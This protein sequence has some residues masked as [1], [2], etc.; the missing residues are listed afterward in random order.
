[1]DKVSISDCDRITAV[2][3]IIK[4]IYRIIISRHVAQKRLHAFVDR[5]EY[6]REQG[7]KI[8]LE[9]K[10]KIDRKKYITNNGEIYLKMYLFLNKYGRGLSK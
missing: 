9:T 7:G 4:Y 5:N 2:E 8:G 1:M 10:A 6:R 3:A